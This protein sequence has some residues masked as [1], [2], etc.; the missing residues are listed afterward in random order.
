M[1][2]IGPKTQGPA[3]VGE[4]DNAAPKD[5]FALLSLGDFEDLLDAEMIAAVMGGAQFAAP[6][7]PLDGEVIHADAT[8]ADDAPLAA[9]QALLAL[10]GLQPKPGMTLDGVDPDTASVLL[11]KAEILAMRSAMLSAENAAQPKVDGKML[12]KPVNL[13]KAALASADVKIDGE[14]DADISEL[15]RLKDAAQEIIKLDAALSDKKSGRGAYDKANPVSDITPYKADGP[16]ARTFDVEKIKSDTPMTGASTQIIAAQ[17]R[18]QMDAPMSEPPRVSASAAHAIE[19]L[20]SSDNGFA[21]G[22]ENGAGG[23]LS[24]Q[25]ALPGARNTT[26]HLDMLTKDWNQKL[27]NALEQRITGGGEEIDF[28]LTPKSLGRMRVSMSMI[29]GQLNL[30]IKTDTA[31]AAAMLGDAESQL[32]QMLEARELRVGSFSAATAG[33]QGQQQG[34]SSNGDKSSNSESRGEAGDDA[35]AVQDSSATA[36]DEDGINVTA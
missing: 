27:A 34:G 13:D 24:Q 17:L 31:M 21:G 28:M 3:L 23:A 6:D 8:N 9:A 22:R 14:I 20:A 15:A 35:E 11:K 32:V 33:D 10:A 18:K 25:S 36:V 29:D 12:P 19:G 7:Q 4:A 30:N 2:E 1:T 26:L 5:I 16:K